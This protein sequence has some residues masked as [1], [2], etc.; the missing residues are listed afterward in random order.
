MSTTISYEVGTH[1]EYASTPVVYRVVS[2]GGVEV[3]RDLASVEEVASADIHAE[4]LSTLSDYLISRANG[5]LGSESISN[6]NYSD[7]IELYNCVVFVIHKLS[8]VPPKENL[9]D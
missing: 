7:L 3:A 9:E 4:Y 1:E 5:V 6:V 8:T 2:V